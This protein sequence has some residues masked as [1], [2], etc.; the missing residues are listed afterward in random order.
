MGLHYSRQNDNEPLILRGYVDSDWAGEK[1]SSLSTTGYVFTLAGS[2]VA[3][4]SQRQKNVATSS[5]HA[6]Y[7]AASEAAK[8]AY[9]LCGW[10]NE[11]AVLDSRI[12][13]GVVP[14]HIDN[15][16]AVKLTKN[17]ESHA[18]T[19]H[20][21]IRYHYIREL[22]EDGTIETIWIPGT[23]NPADMFTKPL[24]APPIEMICKKLGL[25]LSHELDT[26]K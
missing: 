21:D 20:I 7:F 24:A 3:W 22:V 2:P 17:P 5:T 1:S 4:S 19:R 23:E 14:L 6:E 15:E 26:T 13:Q 8:Q 16:S 9:W 25:G 10:M 11:I 12:M 18:R